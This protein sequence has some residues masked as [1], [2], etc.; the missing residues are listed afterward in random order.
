MQ[1]AG[2]NGRPARRAIDNKTP[3]TDMLAEEPVVLRP[4]D[5][6]SS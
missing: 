5:R 3:V 6:S 4:H 1:S 2:P